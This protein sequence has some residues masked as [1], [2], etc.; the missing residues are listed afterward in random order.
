LQDHGAV[1]I[2]GVGKLDL[3][4]HASA[5]SVADEFRRMA[6]ADAV[7]PLLAAEGK[8]DDVA[9]GGEPLPQPV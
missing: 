5:D 6:H 1:E 8:G 9:I 7:H 4:R 3:P 2:A